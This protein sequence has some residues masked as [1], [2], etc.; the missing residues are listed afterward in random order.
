M[1]KMCEKI[2]SS[3][4]LDRCLR[5][6]EQ[7][8][9]ILVASAYSDPSSQFDFLHSIYLTNQLFHSTEIYE[10]KHSDGTYSQ[11]YGVFMIFS[12]LMFLY[13]GFVGSLLLFH[14]YLL[15]MNVTSREL[16]RRHKCN[17]LA[18]VKGNPYFSGIFKN[19]KEAAFVDKNGRYL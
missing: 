1:W 16:F 6:I 15:I 9:Q 5:W 17:Y 13:I 8:L 2:R 12:F 3:L 10:Y 7:P 14:T 4:S 11:E 18:G 19:F